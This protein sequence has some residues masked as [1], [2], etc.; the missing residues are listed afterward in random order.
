MVPFPS[1][2]VERVGRTS[3]PPVLPPAEESGLCHGDDGADLNAVVGFGDFDVATGVGDADGLPVLMGDSSVTSSTRT[4]RLGAVL[5]PT[6][7]TPIPMPTAN[8]ATAME[9][10]KGFMSFPLCLVVTCPQQ[11]SNL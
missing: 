9:M 3:A 7:E 6:L 1:Y 5:L 2:L 11:D 8:A 4:G 10:V